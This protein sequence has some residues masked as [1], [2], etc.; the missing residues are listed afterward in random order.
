MDS[1]VL[2][3][4]YI[5]HIRDDTTRYTIFMTLNPIMPAAIKEVYV[6]DKEPTTI[7]LSPINAEYA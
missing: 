1:G 3:M 6:M 4:G 2:A 5:I 7:P